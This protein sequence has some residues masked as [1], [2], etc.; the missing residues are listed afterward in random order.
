MGR[1]D[2][3]GNTGL[4]EHSVLLS[5]ATGGAPRT[6]PQ[7]QPVLSSSWGPPRTELLVPELKRHT[8]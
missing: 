4:P 5:P 3:L 7:A 2:N 6:Q 1:G 8:G